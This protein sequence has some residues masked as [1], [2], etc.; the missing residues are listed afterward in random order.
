MTTGVLA[1]NPLDSIVFQIR[2]GAVRSFHSGLEQLDK[3]D[4]D[5]VMNDIAHVMKNKVVIDMK[6]TTTES[7]IIETD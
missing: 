7:S 5:T 2:Q 4:Q 3:Q 1:M 6:P